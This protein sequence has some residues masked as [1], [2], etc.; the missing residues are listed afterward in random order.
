MKKD[1]TAKQ[2]N[3]KYRQRLKEKG[4]IYKGFWIPKDFVKD[5]KDMIDF[6]FVIFK[7]ENSEE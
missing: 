1:H 6:H 2:R 7:N 3:I 5:V 4:L